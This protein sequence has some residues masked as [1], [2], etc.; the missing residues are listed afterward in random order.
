MAKFGKKL[1]LRLAALSAATMALSGCYYD[2]GVGLYDGGYNSYDCDPYSPFDTYYDCDNGYGFYNIGYG[3]GWYDSFW[4]PG[5]GMYLFDNYGRRFNMSDNYRRY[6]GE[7]RHQWYRDNH[8]RGG[9]YRNGN[10]YGQ[11]GGGYGSVGRPQGHDRRGHDG[12]GR[13]GDH[14]GNGGYSNGG[15]GQG[16]YRG[17]GQGGRGQGRNGWNPGAQPQPGAVNT[18]PP[19]PP[20]APAPQPG[21]WR[22]GSGGGGGEVHGGG[23]GHGR[24]GGRGAMIDSGGQDFVAPISSPAPEPRYRPQPNGNQGGWQGSQPSAPAPTYTPPAPA[25][26]PPTPT[27]TPPPPPPETHYE[28]PAPAPRDYGNVQPD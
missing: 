23:R 13:G 11:S 10:G 2:M 28:R 5:Y 19:A 8:G 1:A 4:Y 24:G 22:G 14:H 12:D 27:Y 3:G 26:T 7:R 15:Q 9:G 6:W 17:R 18:P 25:Y 21:R 20:S 16:H